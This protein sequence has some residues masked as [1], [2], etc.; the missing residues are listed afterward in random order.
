MAYDPEERHSVPPTFKNQL[1]MDDSKAVFVSHIDKKGRLQEGKE[2][3]TCPKCSG[4]CFIYDS[5]V[6]PSGI[7]HFTYNCTDCQEEWEEVY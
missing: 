2:V 4:Q 7:Q 6:T 3:F 1:I 5:H